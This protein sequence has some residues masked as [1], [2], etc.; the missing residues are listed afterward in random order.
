[1]RIKNPP[2]TEITPCQFDFHNCDWYAIEYHE[3]LGG[4][5]DINNSK[6][7][8][9]QRATCRS[10]HRVWHEFLTKSSKDFIRAIEQQRVMDEQ[11]WTVED[12]REHFS[13]SF[14]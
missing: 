8:N 4:Q 3:L 6:R 2:I 7:Y 9:F 10:C 13:K 5:K 12:W 1:M 14:I 11:G